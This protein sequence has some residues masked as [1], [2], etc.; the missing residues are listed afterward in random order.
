MIQNFKRYTASILLLSS[1]CS[2]SMES[3]KDDLETF[4]QEKLQKYYQKLQHYRAK[5]E[6]MEKVASLTSEKYTNKIKHYQKKLAFFEHITNLKQDN[7]SL[8][9]LSSKIIYSSPLVI[10]LLRESLK[11]T[12]ENIEM[13]REKTLRDQTYH[14]LIT[15]V[16]SG[17]AKDIGINTKKLV[18]DIGLCFSAEDKETNQSVTFST[19]IIKGENTE[20]VEKELK[21]LKI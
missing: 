19:V 21:R 8:R 15:H 20:S 13:L 9:D 4:A 14:H 17:M 16:N 6:V 5:Q 10:N 18:E 1:I 2:Y 3:A 12:P 7:N 11:P